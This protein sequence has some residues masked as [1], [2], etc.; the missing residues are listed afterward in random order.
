MSRHPL[1]GCIQH[2][3]THLGVIQWAVNSHLYP[4]H[5]IHAQQ[6]KCSRRT[7]AFY[8][9]H[10]NG[11]GGV[12]HVGLRSLYTVLGF[13]LVYALTPINQT[14]SATNREP[15][16]S[17]QHTA[18]HTIQN[19]HTEQK[20]RFFRCGSQLS[21]PLPCIPLFSYS[22]LTHTKREKTWWVL[23]G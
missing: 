21:W 11:Q 9:K 23:L 13:V 3:D 17:Q 2:K 4:L 12:E 10:I 5:F 1:G 7:D 16:Q 6:L 20:R 15:A 22:K 18:K 14:D 8:G 19:N